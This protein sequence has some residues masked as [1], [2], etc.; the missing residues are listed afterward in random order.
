MASCQPKP[1]IVAT[2][3]L[4]VAPAV[5]VVVSAVVIVGSMA[6][7]V[8][9]RVM[10]MR[11]IMVVV[12]VMVVF[13][14]VLVWSIGDNHIDHQKLWETRSKMYKRQKPFADLTS[15]IMREQDRTTPPGV[16]P[17]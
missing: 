17:I 4:V 15:K 5:L 2:G 16:F 7:T 9:M 3:E 14:K 13:V 8:V 6:F 12:M 10:R 1:G 11:M